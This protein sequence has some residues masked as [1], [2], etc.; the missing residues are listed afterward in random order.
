MTLHG[1]LRTHGVFHCEHVYSASVGPPSFPALISFHNKSV[2][3]QRMCET[4]H[5]CSLGHVQ[6]CHQHRCGHGPSWL[7]EAFF[8]D[9]SATRGSG[10]AGAE[11]APGG[12]APPADGAPQVR[13]KAGSQ[14]DAF[15]AGVHKHL[16]SADTSSGVEFSV[17]WGIE[18]PS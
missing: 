11:A 5:G 13:G 15:P 8:P 18:G 14:K 17:L 4:R 2:P 12:L 3:S 9:Q 1:S 7:P 10:C 6:T 16:R